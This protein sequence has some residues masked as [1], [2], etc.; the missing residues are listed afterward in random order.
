M[1]FL[2][3][4]WMVLWD[5]YKIYLLLLYFYSINKCSLKFRLFEYGNAQKMCLKNILSNLSLNTFYVNC[6]IVIIQ[7]IQS[8]NCTA[9]ATNG[10]N[11]KFCWNDKQI[12]S[13][14]DVIHFSIVL[15]LLIVYKMH[16]PIEI[17][18]QDT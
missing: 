9:T 8:Y 3:L 10:D 18:F 6:K 7:C 2:L 4:E 17:M 15:A 16:V 13:I 11:N 14:F 5:K 1:V 12:F